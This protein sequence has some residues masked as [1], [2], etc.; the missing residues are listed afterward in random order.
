MLNAVALS[1]ILDV[2]EYLFSGLT[3]MKFQHA[4]QSLEPLTVKYST[5]RSEWES[6][7]QCMLLLFTAVLP[8]FFLL[9]PFGALMIDVK[10]ELCE[11][12]QTFVID[13]NADTQ[14]TYGFRTQYDRSDMS[15]RVPTVSELAVNEHKFRSPL[16]N[17]VLINFAGNQDQFEAERG[18]SM[19]DLATA[20]PICMQT[21]VDALGG[22][23]NSDSSMRRFAELFRRSA[24][25]AIGMPDLYNCSELVDSC[26]RHD[27]RLL[28][29]SCGQT[30]GC[31]DS[32]SMPWY[33]VPAQG[34]ALPCLALA[35]SAASCSDISPSDPAWTG[36]FDLY[37]TVLSSYF[38]NDIRTNQVWPQ[39]DALLQ[40]LKSTGCP[41]LQQFPSDFMTGATWCAGDQTLFR[42]LAW[43]CPET[44]GCTNQPNPPAYCPTLCQSQTNASA[45]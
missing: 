13:H 12:N 37:A 39:T 32:R 1:A 18:W 24:S 41:L 8:Y 22:A 27:A 28:R 44:C 31:T 5:R 17:P 43:L 25:A 11:G 2:D 40:Q 42:G 29:Y 9:K 6:S 10:I 3:P 23:M 30:C 15:N 35:Q 4:I 21:D 14:L 38:G 33:K 36:F 7:F 16:A 34:C 20:Y 45:S 26:D 19:A